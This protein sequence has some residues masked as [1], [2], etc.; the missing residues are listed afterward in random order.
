[1]PQQTWNFEGIPATPP[2]SASGYN[3]EGIPE[4][5]PN[6]PVHPLSNGAWVNGLWYADTPQPDEPPDSPLVRGAM[7]FYRKSPVAAGVELA[8]GAANVVA[9]PLDTWL[10]AKPLANTAKEM[11][12]AQWDQAVQAAQKTKEAAA[13]G[14][15]LSAAE[16]VGHGMAAV[17]PILG[18]MA[19]DVGE[20]F[21]RG[22]IAGG[23]GGTLGLGS[24]LFAPKIKDAVGSHRA[25]TQWLR[26]NANHVQG[27]DLMTD[28]LNIKKSGII[29]NEEFQ[30]AWN[31]IT[32]SRSK[33]TTV[34]QRAPGKLIG[35][36]VEVG[37]PLEGVNDVAAV[38]RK[39]SDA[40][41]DHTATIVQQF[42]NVQTTTTPLAD[43]ATVLGKNSRSDFA[44][45]GQRTLLGMWKDLA[46]YEDIVNATGKVIGRRLVP[47]P[48]TLTRAEAIRKAV[49][50]ELSDRLGPV[51]QQRI[52]TDMID[53]DPSYAA[54]DALAKSLRVGIDGAL[55]GQGVQGF[56]EFRQ[57]QSAVIKL[58]EAA[59]KVEGKGY[60]PV[61]RTTPA[62]W[63]RQ[64]AA[65]L[66][67][68]VGTMAGAEVGGPAG[69]LAGKTLGETVRNRVMPK[70]TRDAAV[71]KANA[72]MKPGP[73]QPMPGPPQPIPFAP[74][75]AG[76][77]S[78]AG[79]APPAGG[80]AGPSGGPSGGVPARMGAGPRPSGGRPGGPTGGAA[81]RPGESWESWGRRNGVPPMWWNREGWNE[82]DAAQSSGTTPPW[83]LAGPQGLP[84]APEPPPE[85]YH[86]EIVPPSGLPTGPQFI[87]GTDGKVRPIA[88]A[89][90]QIP[91]DTVWPRP[92]M[93]EG[94]RAPK[95]DPSFVKAV[96]GAYAQVFQKAEVPRETAPSA[97]SGVSEAPT[98]G[99]QP[100][101]RPRKSQAWSEA[102]RARLREDR[103][104]AAQLEAD[105]LDTLTQRLVDAGH[106]D[107][108]D[109]IRGRL[110]DDLRGIEELHRDA[111]EG[112][113]NGLVLLKAIAKG[114][115][116]SVKAETAQ[117]G[118]IAW[119][120]EFSDTKP[121]AS[122]KNLKAPPVKDSGVF[123][124]VRGVMRV[125][126]GLSLDG[127]VEH[128][129]QDPRFNHIKTI[130][131]LTDALR[132]AATERP[133]TADAL[134]DLIYHT[135]RE[136]SGRLADDL[137]GIEELHG[138][139]AGSTPTDILDTGEA[140]PRLPGAIVAGQGG[141]ATTFR[142]PQQASGSDFSLE[143]SGPKKSA[144]D[145]YASMFDAEVQPVATFKAYGPSG[146]LY[147]IAGGPH[148]RSTV[149]ADKLKALGIEVPT[150][151]PPPAQRVS[152]AD[153]RAKAIS[154]RR[155]KEL[156]EKFGGSKKN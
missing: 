39:V 100:G 80:G 153:L 62:G 25:S 22:D 145:D 55:E 87:V 140:Q 112:G 58:Q 70:M 7:E 135:E 132:N 99:A 111:A 77:P 152:G 126:G 24:S 91:A 1:M 43:V 90:P 20:H 8:K 107:H 10:G 60:Q 118:E 131:D 48:L 136:L 35:R 40:M 117:K 5:D 97:N 139:A 44:T 115:G 57:R 26:D 45:K 128:L 74:P 11:V 4:I 83:G 61:T 146:P 75:V 85:V 54:L 65:D 73:P 18:P 31:E 82:F 114:G 66:A 108:P 17:L 12:K 21:G 88:K 41:S 63:A 143:S 94:Y 141:Q 33:S 89:G 64:T 42:P 125:G 116:I 95:T 59:E 134:K 92:A 151:P 28:A 122:R 148:D 27:T 14:G 96:K 113:E 76:R 71:R 9:H 137:R 106:P 36:K 120:K 2:P 142:A 104:A 127:M 68:N 47:D 81:P 149:S 15:V 105:T 102:T 103:A 110:A 156:L 155:M 30:T 121:S 78:A 38:T 101:P 147:D 50:K 32:P 6:T 51:G 119:L 86:G 154:D 133:E 52:R 72:L 129:S 37:T 109:A 84:P 3:F 93:A 123:R 79:T 138:D 150:T 69:A 46:H 34:R 29:T 19:A 56:A 130:N 49:N 53:T 67:P 144:Y 124:G 98:T 23:V 16:A 13:G